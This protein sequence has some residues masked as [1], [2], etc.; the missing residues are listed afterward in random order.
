MNLTLGLAPAPVKNNCHVKSSI[1][2]NDDSTDLHKT[3]RS[4]NLEFSLEGY[5]GGSRPRLLTVSRTNMA[6]K[7]APNSNF[8]I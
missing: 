2:N 6:E 1:G 5:R 7:V 8:L 4:K 3:E